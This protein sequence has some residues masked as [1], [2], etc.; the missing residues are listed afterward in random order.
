MARLR[1][2]AHFVPGANEK[3]LGK[4]LSLAADALV[5]DLEDAVTPENKD[6][7]RRTVTRWLDEVDFGRQER[8]VRMNPLDSPWGRRDLEET[9][10]VAPDAYLVPKVRSG[11]D[12]REID[13][14]L[15]D[16]ESRH[17]HE[18]GAVKLIVLGTETPEGVLNIA[19]LCASPRAD[20]LSWGAEDLSAA[21]GARRNRDEHGAFLEVFRYCRVMTLLAASA[22]GVQPLDTVFVDV[23]DTEGLRRECLEGAWMGFTGKITIHPSQV[24]IVN[25]VFTPSPDEIAESRELLE[26]FEENRKAGRMAFS[27]KGQMVDVPHLER[28]RKLLERAR[29]ADV[30]S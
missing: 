16:L 27:F 5:L 15:T 8:I 28:A 18:A 10:A 20:A 12:V 2:A 7:A 6:E 26:A 13:A 11:D 29:Q 22:A 21:I 23:R 1:R 24:D 14:L 4:S 19:S 30:D 9:M 3:M 17:G 25:E